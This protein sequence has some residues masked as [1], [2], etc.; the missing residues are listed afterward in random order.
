MGQEKISCPDCLGK[1]QS[2]YAIRNGENG[3]ELLLAECPRCK[4]KGNL[5][6][7]DFINK[8]F[9]WHYRCSCGVLFSL[10]KAEYLK[11]GLKRVEEHMSDCN[12]TMMGCGS[13]PAPVPV[14]KGMK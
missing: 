5:P 9:P 10:G 8:E 11:Y 14:V 4:G 12:G 1:G 7:S 2:F 3:T 13:P 6:L